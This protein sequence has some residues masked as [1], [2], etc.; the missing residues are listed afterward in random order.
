MK[1]KHWLFLGAAA[2]CASPLSACSSK[3]DACSESRTCAPTNEAGAAGAGAAGAGAEA[4]AAGT[5]ENSGGDGG[6]AGERTTNA[7]AGGESEA[8]AGGEAGATP[9]ACDATLNACGKACVDLKADPKNCGKDATSVYW[10]VTE[11]DFQTIARV[12]K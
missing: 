10:I 5:P 12:A 8:G 9:V 2:I 1:P 6:A 4:G 3:F 11:S 7:G